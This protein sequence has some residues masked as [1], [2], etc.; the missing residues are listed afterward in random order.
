MSSALD[1]DRLDYLRRDSFCTGAGYGHFNWQRLLTTI[2][3]HNEDLVWPEKAALAIEE[4]IFARYYMYQNVYLHKTTRGF[5]Q[6]LQA[7][8]RRANQLRL[9]GVDVQPNPVLEQFWKSEKPEPGHLA[10]SDY[11]RLEEF[12]V[13]EQ[14]QRWTTHEDKALADIARRFLNRDGFAMIEP[15]PPIDPLKSDDFG[16]WVPELHKLLLSKG[17]ESPEMY[18]LQDKVELK[19]LRPYTE[20]KEPENQSSVN[21]IRIM[22]DGK[23]KAIGQQMPRLSAVISKTQDRVTFYVPKEIRKEANEL[24]RKLR[25]S[26][27]QF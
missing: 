25:A 6:L 12:T 10:V 17:Y 15:P 3:L 13:L 21:T 8:W 24:S 2:E 27:G 9:G 1:M 20:E 22:V 18:C 4:Y 5:E 23:P 11:L 26:R 16:E 7:M 14:I 19:Y